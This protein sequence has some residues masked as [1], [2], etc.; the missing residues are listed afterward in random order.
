MDLFNQIVELMPSLNAS[1]TSLSDIAHQQGFTIIPLPKDDDQCALAGN[2]YTCFTAEKHVGEYTL[3]IEVETRDIY[4]SFGNDD[5][6]YFN[7][8]C[9]YKGNELIDSKSYTYF[10]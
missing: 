10:K 5:E 8:L 7:T 9:L 4:R 6:P 2:R 3:T 1:C